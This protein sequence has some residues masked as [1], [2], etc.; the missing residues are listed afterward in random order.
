MN[1][2]WF[3]L[4]KVEMSDLF[5]FSVPRNCDLMNKINT[6]EGKDQGGKYMIKKESV[7][8]VQLPEKHS[9]LSQTLALFTRAKTDFGR[10]QMGAI[11]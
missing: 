3:A 9:A 5:L 2:F 1:I 4:E 11:L 10:F 7:S 6:A 8:L